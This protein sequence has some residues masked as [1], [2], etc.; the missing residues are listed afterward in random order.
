MLW[1]EPLWLCTSNFLVKLDT[2]K[3]NFRTLAHLLRKS[4]N[5]YRIF[6]TRNKLKE[7]FVLNIIYGYFN[8]FSL[9]PLELIMPRWL[10]SLTL[11][12]S[13]F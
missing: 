13:V 9:L 11:C 12:S 6:E 5:S 7:R 2:G 8:Y 1:A 4:C 10:V 3:R